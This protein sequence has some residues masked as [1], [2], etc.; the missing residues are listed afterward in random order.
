MSRA[1]Y[2]KTT[3]AHYVGYRPP[4]H[5]RLLRIA[6]G[7]EGYDRGLDIGCGT[8]AS[9]VALAEYCSSVTGIDPSIDMI[10]QVDTTSSHISYQLMTDDHLDFENG[11]F[12]IV[13]LAGSWHY[14]QSPRLLSEIG[15]VLCSQGRL[16]IYDFQIQTVLI[17]SH[18]GYEAPVHRDGYDYQVNLSQY[19]SSCF[20]EKLISREHLSFGISPENLAH[21]LLASSS[22]YPIVSRGAIDPYPRLLQQ[23]RRAYHHRQVHLT[24]KAFISLYQ[25][26]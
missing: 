12:D 6:L 26:I 10:E 3:A 8:G 17:L 2:D 25:K 1:K 11:S 9:T 7:D 20:A 21:L 14:A 18:L 22:T 23:I 15:R 5:S 19:D 13:T 4:L 24:A 16:M